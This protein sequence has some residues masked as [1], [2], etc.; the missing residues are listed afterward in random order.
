MGLNRKEVF[1]YIINTLDKNLIERR[2]LNKKSIQD[3]VEDD[4][5]NLNH[6]ESNTENEIA[7]LSR[8]T[9]SLD[10]L[11]SCLDAMNELVLYENT[12]EKIGKGTIVDTNGFIFIVGTSLPSLNYEQKK[13]VGVAPDAPVYE[14]L[15]SKGVGENLQLGNTQEAILGIY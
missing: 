6:F 7:D 10:Y 4:D 9:M 5:N 12:G 15:L 14:T 8:E 1:E 2:E 13:V 3:M 11:A